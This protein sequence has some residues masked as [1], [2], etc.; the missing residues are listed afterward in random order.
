MKTNK[1]QTALKINNDLLIEEYFEDV[2]LIGI[3]STSE[4]YTLLSYISQ[5]LGFHFKRDHELEIQNAGIFFPVFSFEEPVKFLSH[6]F[7]VNRRKTS[8]LLN[9]T[10]RMDFFW[11]IKGNTKRQNISQTLL[12]LIMKISGVQFCQKITP[13][14]L[15]QKELLMF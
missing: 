8:Y 6:Y 9:E 10:P 11:M 2:L 5:Q 1:K 3:S 7:F 15:H 12:S 4:Y 13:E 14:L